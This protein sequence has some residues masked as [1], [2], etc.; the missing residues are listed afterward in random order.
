MGKATCDKLFLAWLRLIHGKGDDPKNSK[1]PWLSCIKHL[2]GIQKVPGSVPGIS[3]Q[4]VQVVGEV[5]GFFQGPWSA[6]DSLTR[7]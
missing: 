3:K 1:A 2:L 5:N 7:H 6:S 4:K